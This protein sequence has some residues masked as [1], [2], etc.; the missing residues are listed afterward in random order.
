MG[1]EA[2]NGREVDA[3]KRER[4]RLF[5]NSGWPGGMC[6]ELVEVQVRKGTCWPRGE[7]MIPKRHLALWATALTGCVLGEGRA[8]GA[9]F[10]GVLH[11]TYLS[12]V[13][14]LPYIH[15]FSATV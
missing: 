10:R 11:P 13:G 15:F 9:S 7:S 6:G 4:D 12:I 3:R 14:I 8:G 1:L 5:A 2:R